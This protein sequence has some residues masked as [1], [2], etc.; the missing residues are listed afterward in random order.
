MEAERTVMK[1]GKKTD[2]SV[3][4]F[5]NIYSKKDPKKGAQTMDEGVTKYIVLLG[6]SLLAVCGILFVRYRNRKGE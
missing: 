5:T 3:F 4:T 2:V 6:G 1:D